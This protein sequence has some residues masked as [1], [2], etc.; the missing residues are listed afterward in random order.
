MK[1]AYIIGVFI[2][3]ADR[4]ENVRLL[5]KHY[6]PIV[7]DGDKIYL[8]EICPGGIPRLEIE[9]PNV[10]HVILEG[11]GFNLSLARNLGIK[12]ALVDDRPL[13]SI[14]DA[15]CIIP[16]TS[17]KKLQEKMQT[18]GVIWGYPFYETLYSIPRNPYN[19]SQVERGTPELSRNIVNMMG[20]SKLICVSMFYM[21]NL[22]RMNTPALFDERYLAWGPEDKD[23]YIRMTSLYGM[24]HRIA[25]N[26][27][28]INH[29]KVGGLFY[30]EAKV[31]ES[32]A[33]FEETHG[34]VLFNKDYN[35][36]ILIR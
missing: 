7:E 35:N 36:A 14:I 18:D 25:G 22:S 28:H 24:P 29:A 32:Y 5:L 30:S 12:R 4:Q 8:I 10:E 2:D 11:E 26:A 17:I 3:S 33:L 19:L 16:L 21:I 13:V 9:S 34:K 23:F 15:D 20:M 1:K 6:I 31:K 27:F